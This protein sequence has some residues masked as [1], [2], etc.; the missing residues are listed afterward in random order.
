[1]A[2]NR[3]ITY[4]LSLTVGRALS[5]AKRAKQ[6]LD[7]I[8]KTTINTQGA[9]KA[10]RET[11][12]LQQQV[13]QGQ[14]AQTQA[15]VQA[16][17]AG[18][19]RMTQ[20]ARQAANAQIQ[21]QNRVTANLQQQAAQQQ[22]AM[23][24]ATSAQ[25][26]PAGGGLASRLGGLGSLAAGGVI[27]YLGTIGAREIGRAAVEM[28]DL[29][30]KAL[31]AEAAFRTLSG[32]ASAAEKNIRAI[33]SAS[34]GTISRLDAMQTGV[35]A[36]ALGL[37]KTPEEFEKV[38]RAATAVTQVSPV[39][40][41]LG[42][43]FSEIGLAS[44]N[45]SFR[46]LDQLG[47]SVEEIRAKIAELKSENDGLS[48]SQAFQTAVVD[49]LVTKYDDLLNSAEAQATGLERLR[50]SAENARVELAKGIVMPV[51][52]AAAGAGAAA[53]TGITNTTTDAAAD[54]RLLLG[55]PELEHSIQR[56]NSLLDPQSFTAQF[57]A[58]TDSLVGKDVNTDELRRVLEV[59]EQLG[60]AQTANIPYFDLYESAF[61]R[62]AEQAALNNG[63]TDENAQRLEVLSRSLERV[64]QNTIEF[65]EAQAEAAQNEYDLA[66]L[67][68]TFRQLD[69][70]IADAAA[71]TPAQL[72][73]ADALV[74]SLINLKIEI[75]AAGGASEE[76]AAAL[77]EMDRFL[78]LVAAGSDDVAA[79]AFRM[80]HALKSAI[81]IAADLSGSLESQ[82]SALV[83]DG[84]ISVDQAIAL[85]EKQQK[86]I[87]D[88]A[89]D[90]ANSGMS[91]PEQTFALA[92]AQ[93]IASEEIRLIQETA[94]ARR[95]ANQIGLQE[96]Q[97][98]Y[99][100]IDAMLQ[101][102]SQF[103]ESFLPGAQKMQQD[104]INLRMEIAA[105]GQITDQ[106]RAML[107][108]YSSTLDIAANA[109]G[110]LGNAQIQAAIASGNL[111]S[112]LMTIP[113]YLDAVKISA[114]QAG[115]AIQSVFAITNQL[116]GTAQSRLEALVRSG[117]ITPGQ[118]ETVA[119][120]SDVSIQQ[121]ASSIGYSGM[122]DREKAFA[123]AGAE[124][125][126]FEEITHIEEVARLREEADRKA[127]QEAERAF[128]GAAKTAGQE[129]KDLASD[130]R[131]IPGLFGTSDVTEAD[132]LKAQSGLYQDKPDEWLRRLRDEVQNGKDYEDVSIEQAREALSRVGIV[133]AENAEDVLAQVEE[134]WNN[135][136][137]FSDKA[138]LELINQ[139][140][141]Q[142]QLE[143]KEKS[144]QGQ[145]NI[146]EYF[147]VVVDEAVGAIT[148]GGGA[149]PP[150][151]EIPEIKIPEIEADPRVFAD[152]IRPYTPPDPS[153]IQRLIGPLPG[154][155]DPQKLVAA[156]GSFD[157]S[158]FESMGGSIAL[159]IQAGFG[160]VTLEDHAQKYH[161]KIWPQFRGEG[162]VPQYKSLGGSVA[163]AIEAGYNEYLFGDHATE[164]YNDIRPQF[165]G[166]MIVPQFK[167]IG[168]GVAMA[169]EAGYKEYLWQDLATDMVTELG[170]QFANEEL[171]KQA[172]G[173]G[174]DVA[175]ELA[176]GMTTIN[177]ALAAKEILVGLNGG[178]N[179]EE[180]LN[181]LHSAAGGLMNVIR[182][183]M[184]ARAKQP[185]WGT[186]L[187]DE[188]LN[189]VMSAA[190][191]SLEAT[192]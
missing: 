134:A 141:V 65:N 162:I 82:L 83:S 146:M 86:F 89:N 53:I 39:I 28:T 149:T 130:L 124:A 109:V 164:Y 161:D 44:A 62:I 4:K 94:K 61:T 50:V 92:E 45:E 97:A 114:W 113:G 63:L 143:L 145:Q 99:S 139:D 22:R 34:G 64:T 69:T 160:A 9:Q 177:Y 133:A 70:M 75:A 158:Q 38:T 171:V 127:A 43:A 56:I 24:A 73:G 16:V 19:Q 181:F 79:S 112:A 13:T 187:F 12:R 144:R 11:Q 152:L 154:P 107:S 140:A 36:L 1:M 46:R 174:G 123:V 100:Q 48:N 47:L 26:A 137:L 105:T 59:F 60:S 68:D 136:V 173:V 167:G 163:M 40:S 135:S 78:D 57:G 148:G 153:T 10:A 120:R 6:A 51:V 126:V 102:S 151:I 96:Q 52:N 81:G 186:A 104:L 18:Q 85:Y 37:A 156:G 129:F 7:D 138:N 165:S 128:K 67:T 101:R 74:Q 115:A 88:T 30:T 188:L 155:P 182:D 190:T 14:K 87:K 103:D 178:F 55:V 116:S 122:S 8:G 80:G 27:G 110:Y 35:Q 172:Q 98:F 176:H 33:E 91:G 41:D 191:D 111:N 150:K 49:T 170:T 31:R 90:V 84:A 180:N 119:R 168:G 71:F 192:G 23:Q 169:V 25:S 125:V 147:G 93:R 42:S 159:A 29:A 117:T 108:Q 72:S 132:M 185:G 121:Q 3:E 58:F 5:D 17:Q 179:V 106:Q 54:W 77:A 76:Q 189:A 95:D 32:G 66:K 118:A 131:G 142:M 183:G 157:E 15:Q 20:V 184:I 2:D 21:Q 166:E 175:A